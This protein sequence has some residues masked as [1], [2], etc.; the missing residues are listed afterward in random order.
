MRI[1]RFA[2]YFV[3]FA[4]LLLSVGCTEGDA[5]KPGGTTGANEG[6]DT[7]VIMTPHPNEVTKEFETAFVAHC[8]EKLARAVTI[9]WR[10][11]DVGTEGQSRFIMNRF[12]LQPKGIGID[13]FFGGGI[14]PYRTLK[15]KG[16]LAPHKAANID[17]IPPKI[18]GVDLY[19][20]DHMWYG[21]AL[22][23]F[24]IL[25]NKVV[26]KKAG[27]P[28]PKTW[29]DMAD[30]RL[31]R[32]VR[33]ADP[34]RSGSALA[35]YEIILQAYGWE[36]GLGVMTLM[37][38]NG[39]GTFSSSSSQVVGEVAKG[40]YAMGP[41]ID[42]YGLSKIAEVGEDELGFVLPAKLT[43]ITPDP[44][45][46]LKGA[47]NMELAKLFVDFVLSEDGQKIWMFDKG[48]E[49]GPAKYNLMRMSV[50]PGFHKKYRDRIKLKQSPFDMTDAFTHDSVKGSAR[51]QVVID[52]IKSTLIDPQRELCKSW[53]AIQKSP[54]KAELIKEMLAV[55]VS[56]KEAV[57]LARN[58]WSDEAFRVRKMSEWRKLARKKYAAANR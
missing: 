51:R 58:K 15:A 28:E 16:C 6:G 4:L 24:G 22:S 56:E 34:S 46:I 45:A 57:D 30:P 52:L 50:L 18:L 13:L 21:A 29:E 9:E 32:M 20:K 10:D 54:K 43:V 42:Y 5:S 40:E 17:D 12:E 2:A 55:L 27:I 1:H 37:A 33:L 8:R 11:L 23:S 48:S 38:A 19:D 44:V 47:P 36:R 53:Q 41:A 39:R 26:L 49:G 35:I 14:D 3:T 25:Y 7:L 31:I